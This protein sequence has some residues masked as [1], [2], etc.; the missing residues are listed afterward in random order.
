M[1]QTSEP[2]RTR[3]LAKRYLDLSYEYFVMGAPV[4][5][6]RGCRLEKQSER[7]DQ[8]RSRLFDRCSFARDVKL[9]TQRHK[10]VVLALDDCRQ[11]LCS[12]HSSSLSQCVIA[13]VM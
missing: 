8:I 9:R 13:Y 1:R 2:E 4:N 7:L 5:L 12:F 3:S 6:G 11:A 10:S